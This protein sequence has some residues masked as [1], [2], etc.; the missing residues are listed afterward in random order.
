MNFPLPLIVAFGVLTHAASAVVVNI[1][2]NSGTNTQSGLAAAPDA[3]GNTAWNGVQ[4]I[5][6]GVVDTG[7]LNDSS[8]VATGITLDIT[9]F[10]GVI[11]AASGEQELASGHLNLMRDYLRLDTTAGTVA[12]ATGIVSGLTAGAFYEIYLYGQGETFA[13]SGTS[14]ARGQNTRFTIGAESKATGWDTVSGGN[15]VLTENVEYVKFLVAADVGG[16]ITFT[17]SNIISSIN[18]PDP[19][20][21]APGSRFAALNGIQL[22]SVPEVSAALLGGLGMLALLVRRHR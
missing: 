20:G 13:D 3:P 15:G 18:G 5:S 10:T 4:Q 6:A 2:F 17:W 14:S 9:G 22:V 21:F 7:V 16:T 11:A 12:T 19:D 8:G 1:D